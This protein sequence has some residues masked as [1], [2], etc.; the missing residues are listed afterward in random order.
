MTPEEQ[1]N[2][3]VVKV[4]LEL[5]DKNWPA[6]KESLATQLAPLFAVVEAGQA[7]INHMESEDGKLCAKDVK[8]AECNLLRPFVENMLAALAELQKVVKS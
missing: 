5:S 4:A 6:I 2:R 7:L 3:F 8:C 1:K